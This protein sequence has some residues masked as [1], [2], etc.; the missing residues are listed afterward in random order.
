MFADN[1]NELSLS[2]ETAEE[3]HA[4][5]NKQGSPKRQQMRAV[6]NAYATFQTTADCS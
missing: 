5:L 1:G 3:I 2:F 4:K 6:T